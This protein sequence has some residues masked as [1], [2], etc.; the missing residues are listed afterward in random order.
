MHTRVTAS[1]SEERPE[2]GGFL[3][4]CAFAGEAQVAFAESASERLQELL[5]EQAAEHA[6]RKEDRT[7]GRAIQREPSGEIPSPGHDAVQVRM[8]MRFRSW[9]CS[10][11]RNPIDA[12]RCRGSAAMV[13]SVSE[14]ARK[15]MV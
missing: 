12:P 10:T 2:S 3:Q 14:A 4:R 13:S 5:P 6:H 15:R 7:Y 9:V 11:A 1:D 8:E